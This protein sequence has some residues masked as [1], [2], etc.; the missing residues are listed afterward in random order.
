MALTAS[1]FFAN[2]AFFAAMIGGLLFCLLPTSMLVDRGLQP[3][4]AVS[5]TCERWAVP[6]DRLPD[7]S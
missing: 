4:R 5:V 6:S 2:A 1:V 3:G 7:N